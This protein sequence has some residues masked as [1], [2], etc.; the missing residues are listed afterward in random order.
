MV[1]IFIQWFLKK[2]LSLENVLR[3]LFSF[4]SAVTNGFTPEFTH[5]SLPSDA[6]LWLELPFVTLL[7]VKYKDIKKNEL[8]ILCCKS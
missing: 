4:L 3:A 2:N 5:S 7:V 8:K 6:S 1:C